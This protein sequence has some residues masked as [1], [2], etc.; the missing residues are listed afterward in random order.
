MRE[1]VLELGNRRVATDFTLK[2][3]MEVAQ[4]SLLTLVHIEVALRF[5]CFVSSVV[6]QLLSS[7]ASEASD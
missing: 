7:L 4:A 6:V 1:N 5:C 3:L 2:V